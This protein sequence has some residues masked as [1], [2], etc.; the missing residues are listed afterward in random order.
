M[1]TN[2]GYKHG[3]KEMKSVIMWSNVGGN[4]EHSHW[5]GFPHDPEF[6][7]QGPRGPLRIPCLLQQIFLLVIRNSFSVCIRDAYLY[8]CSA[9][10][11]NNL[12]ASKCTT[13]VPFYPWA[14][15]KSLFSLSPF[16]VLPL[17][18]HA[19][20]APLP[21]T[22]ENYCYYWTPKV[23]F[24]LFIQWISFWQRTVLFVV[25]MS[26]AICILMEWSL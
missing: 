1:Q 22:W 10:I 18:L 9:V 26:E 17:L 8:D 15:W 14:V 13:N 6:H 23:F 2:G 11:V 20:S 16:L 12:S 4:K 19:F 7:K 24:L 21:L 3:I 25:M 5:C